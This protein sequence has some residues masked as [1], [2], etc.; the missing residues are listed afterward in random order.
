MTSPQLHEVSTRRNQLYLSGIS[1]N[2]E[3]MK[4]QVRFE[5][6]VKPVVSG[7]TVT[8]EGKSIHIRNANEVTLYISIGTN[9]KKYNDLNGNATE[10]ARNYLKETDHKSFSEILERQKKAYQKYFNRVQLNLGVTDSVRNPTDVRVKQFDHD[11]DPQLAA[12]YF[13]YGRYLLISSSQPGG[14]PA[15]LQGIW[16]D[17]MRPPWD[18][19]YT[20]N[21]NL[22]MNYW[23]AEITGLPEMEGPVIQ[24]AKDLS[25]TGQQA[26]REMYGARGWVVHHN[27]DLWRITGIVDGP[28]WGLWP[29]GG[30]WLCENLWRHYM[31]TGNEA[32]LNE[33]Y[34]LLK[35][36]SKYFID[37][38]Q[39]E[40]THHWLVVSPSISPEHAYMFKDHVPISI[41]DGST[42]DNQLVFD[43]FSHTIK[44]ADLLHKDPTFADTL[45]EKRSLLPPMQI[46]QYS[47]LQEWIKDW[48]KTD[49]HHRHVSH[50]YGLFPSNQISVYRTPKLAQAARQSLIYRGDAGTGWSVAWKMNLWARLLDGDHAYKLLSDELSPAYGAV[51]FGQGHTFVNLFDAISGKRSPFQIDANFG[52]TSGIAEMLLQSQDGAVFVLPA[53]PHKWKNGSV[54]GLRARG[55]FIVDIAWKNGKMDKL[56]IHSE[57]GGNCRVRSYVSLKP[58]G[59]FL[60]HKATGTNPNPFF[61]VPLVKK[62]LISPKAHSNELHLQ[63]TYLYDFNAKPGK[64][65]HFVAGE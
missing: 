28:F 11:N 65:Y 41:T 43:L 56:T 60:L 17:S 50:L 18:S 48:D 9:F 52:V 4:G 47:Q 26:A 40:P 51:K 45:R 3:N 16:N 29:E 6:I 14:Q 33:I 49:D 22:E 57:H 19:K 30:T 24:M 32:Y 64:T 13:Q 12:L 59:N 63:K 35:G 36:A 55:G 15:N 31:F 21:I 46:G 20:M 5:T 7:G 61:S 38:L 34:P 10:Q 54:K 53:L 62:P 39:V 37:E 27:T 23:P 58:S 2:Q 1:G 42:M 44:A 8:T 25:V